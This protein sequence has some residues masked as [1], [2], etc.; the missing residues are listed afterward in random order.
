[1]GIL[2]GID[3][4]MLQDLAYGL[5][6]GSASGQ[7]LAANLGQAGL[8][9]NKS[10]RER[11]D[12]R[13]RK[14]M[15]ELQLKQAQRAGERADREDI[16]SQQMDA[17]GP[18][19]FQPEQAP[20]DGM[21]PPAPPREDVAGYANALMRINPQA[22]LALRSS[23]A[24]AQQKQYQKVSP[25]DNLVDL[26]G[27]APKVVLQGKPKEQ[28]PP[29]GM[30]VGP[31]GKWEYD[32]TWLKGQ[33]GLKVAGRTVIS[34]MTKIENYMP[35]SEEAQ[36]EFMK[37]SRVTYDQLKQAPTALLNIEKAKA[38]IPTAKGFVGTGGQTLLEAAKFLNNRLGL[39]IDTA[40]VTSAEELRSRIFFNIM[41]NLKKMDSQ[42]SQQQQ[43]IM[44]ES[45]G[46]LGT[47]PNALPRVLDAF[48]EVIRGKIDIHNKEVGSAIARGV[49]FPYDPIINL[50]ANKPQLKK[51]ATA[52]A[53]AKHAI[54]KQGADRAAVIQRM[55]DNGF[56][57]SGL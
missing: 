44:Q 33:T 10:A 20:Q 18:Q 56:D 17:L 55:E 45:L 26:S 32:E 49:K 54:D 3:P 34:P 50:T 11:E 13:A 51:N 48:A 41:D 47:D 6:S 2:D 27:P 25:E 14:K 57:T 46:S 21:G 9:A 37:G 53:K 19:F 24:Q 39:S 12:R 1:M 31:D 35:A 4:E 8:L 16:R 5:L 23:M 28:P 29:T 40:G 7:G 15:E 43:Q 38:L 52:T 42:P 36:R 22:G 30:R